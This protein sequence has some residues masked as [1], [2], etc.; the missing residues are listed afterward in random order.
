MPNPTLLFFIIVYLA[1]VP[2][3]TS[4]NGLS[5]ILLKISAVGPTYH[6]AFTAGL[7]IVGLLS[8]NVEKSWRLIVVLFGIFG[9]LVAV[10]LG[11]GFSNVSD[12]GTLY[13]WFMPLLLFAVYER[14]S[15]L[16]DPVARR[17]LVALF[18]FLPAAYGT[19]ITISALVYVTTGFEATTFEKGTH[20]FSGFA[21]AF[22]P[23]INALFLCAYVNFLLEPV[24]L[25]RMVAYC[26]SFTLLKSKTAVAYVAMALMAPFRTRWRQARRWGVVRVLVTV[27]LV[28][29]T[30]TLGAMETLKALDPTGHV[31]SSEGRIT[32]ERVGQLLVEG[33]LDWLIFYATDL[34]QWSPLNL[35]IGNGLNIDRRLLNPVWWA[36]LGSAK[37]E[38]AALTK[39]DK[40]P[41]L[42]L[43]GPLDLF[44][45]IGLACYVAVFYGYPL[46][47][48]RLPHFRTFYVFMIFLS[49]V[50]GHL[51]NNPQT[52]T[53]LV[54]FIFLLRDYVPVG[55]S[56]GSGPR[57]PLPVTS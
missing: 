33:R 12:L 38:S 41:E 31:K 22:N 55:S 47:R 39:Y 13:K 52:T 11:A 6:A 57:R 48:I 3:I 27:P 1:G 37:Y 34:P 7:L 10:Q 35:A 28:I 24:G 21:F 49:I 14:W 23:T 40:T 29:M 9:V 20:R 2:L 25:L 51:V 4:I 44:G 36:T 17:R 5:L 16:R 19:L 45:L 42:D 18:Q 8:R 43:L 56:P 50:A 53:L 15:Y 32:V 46:R 54:F 30:L 26:G